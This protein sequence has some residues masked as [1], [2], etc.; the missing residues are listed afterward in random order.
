M[1]VYVNKEACVSCGIC[2]SQCSEV[3]KIGEDN[4]SEVINPD[5]A[6]CECDLKDIA[7][8]CPGQAIVVE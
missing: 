5:C 8:S 7:S 2:E 6:D 1:R 3:F 4:K